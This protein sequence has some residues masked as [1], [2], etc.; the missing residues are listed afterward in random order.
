M[1]IDSSLN[2]GTCVTVELPLMPDASRPS[3]VVTIVPER[4]EELA[5]EQ[6]Q[7]RA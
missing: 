2:V 4:S 6:F 1:H 7:R 5:R 3:R